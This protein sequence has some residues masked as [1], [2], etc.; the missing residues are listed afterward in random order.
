MQRSIRRLALEIDGL[1]K[2]AAAFT[3]LAVLS[4]LRGDDDGSEDEKASKDRRCQ[5]NRIEIDLKERRLS[6]QEAQLR[7]MERELEEAKAAFYTAHLATSQKIQWL[8]AKVHAK[9]TQDQR[10]KERTERERL[11]R[12]ERWRKEAAK[13]RRAEAA[14][15]REQQAKAQIA[16]GESKQQ[17]RHASACDHDNLWDRVKVYGST[18]CLHCEIERQAMLQC[19][20]CGI[21]AC[22]KCQRALRQQLAR[23]RARTAATDV[24]EAPESPPQRPRS[25]ARWN[26]REWIPGQ[27]SEGHWYPG[28]W[29]SGHWARGQRG[30]GQWSEGQ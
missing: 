4:D 29:Q 19:L 7:E 5:E 3:A 6:L 23:K 20:N 2:I 27:M 14:A 30:E 18:H 24:G 9:K 1:A 11:E 10:K 25:Q 26:H 16:A 28:Y 13:A 21:E 12:I 17:Q 22:P 8:E 15:A